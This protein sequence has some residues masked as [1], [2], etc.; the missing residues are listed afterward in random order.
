[1]VGG[2]R[3]AHCFSS[4]LVSRVPS[5][6]PTFEDQPAVEEDL[7]ESVF[8]STLDYGEYGEGSEDVLDDDA[9][10]QASTS[11][12]SFPSL[13]KVG[14]LLAVHASSGLMCRG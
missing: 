3:P 7:S 6:R 4:S 8:A 5:T 1:V 14:C 12:A 11:G 9:D 2:A 13:L 10:S